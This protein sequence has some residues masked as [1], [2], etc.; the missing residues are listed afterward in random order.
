MC[1]VLFPGAAQ[2]STTCQPG[3]G[4]SAWA[5]MQLALLCTESESFKRRAE[6]W[7]GLTWAHEDPRAAWATVIMPSYVT[8][9]GYLASLRGGCG[10]YFCLLRHLQD[11]AATANQ[12][13]VM[14]IGPR[15]EHQDVW[16]QRVHLSRFA[17]RSSQHDLTPRMQLA[18]CA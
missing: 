14:Q 17:L 2:Q 8:D 4:R 15:R 7:R 3:S 11:E 12:R 18:N 10:V 6:V 5:G 1:V 16:Q 9:W 13:M